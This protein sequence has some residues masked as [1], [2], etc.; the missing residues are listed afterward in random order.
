MK[1]RFLALVLAL[2]ALPSF[3]QRRVDLIIDVEGVH[4]AK[5]IE[6]EPNT[7]RYAPQFD[8]GGGL[9]GG[10]NWF[11][12]SR[13][14]LELKVAALGSKLHVRRSGSDFVAVADVGTAEIYPI[15][16]LLQWHLVQHGSFRP[17]IGAG[18]GYVILKNIEKQVIGAKAVEFDDPTGLVVDGGIEIPFG[19]RWS[20]YGDARYTPIETQARARFVGVTETKIDVRPLIIS[21]GLAYHF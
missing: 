4:R 15:T 7:V 18:A 2:V 17:Y 5:K 14:S 11:L 9:G 12:S 19:K 10:V 6:F 13:V 3:A 20:A 16:A 1:V 8:N 21:F